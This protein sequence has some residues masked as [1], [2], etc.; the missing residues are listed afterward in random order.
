MQCRC[1][2]YGLRDNSDSAAAA[3]FFR[4]VDLGGDAFLHSGDVGDYADGFSAGLK[5]LQRGHRDFQGVRIK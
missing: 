5:V 1:E 2:G 3:G 4:Y